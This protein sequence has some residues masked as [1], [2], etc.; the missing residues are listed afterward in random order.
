LLPAHHQ[1]R[2]QPPRTSREARFH[3]RADSQLASGLGSAFASGGR[4]INGT[5]EHRTI[6]VSETGYRGALPISIAVRG[7]HE[8]ELRQRC[9]RI[10]A[11]RGAV[12]QRSMGRAAG[13]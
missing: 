11:E 6:A 4:L 7:W 1:L 10:A 13:R 5:R 2:R 8:M 9:R 12:L 3:E